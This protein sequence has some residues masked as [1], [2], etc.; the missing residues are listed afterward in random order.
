MYQSDIP[1]VETSIGQVWEIKGLRWKV[2]AGEGLSTLTKNPLAK[3][4]KYGAC[5]A[6]VSCAG[7]TK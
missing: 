3:S 4:M 6:T 5:D 7:D 1:R 2:V